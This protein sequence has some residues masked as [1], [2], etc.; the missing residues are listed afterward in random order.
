MNFKEKNTFHYVYDK[1]FQYKF[2]ELNKLII[3]KHFKH[4]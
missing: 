1:D 3:N 4:Y 2:T